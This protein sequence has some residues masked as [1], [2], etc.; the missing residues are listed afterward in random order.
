MEG[1]INCRS[2]SAD[3]GCSKFD[4]ARLARLVLPARVRTAAD[5]SSHRYQVCRREDLATHG[6]DVAREPGR[7]RIDIAPLVTASTSEGRRYQIPARPVR[8]PQPSFDLVRHRI[9]VALCFGIRQRA[10]GRSDLLVDFEQFGTHRLGAV[11]DR[12]HGRFCAIEP[13][14]GSTGHRQPFGCGTFFCKFQLATLNRWSV[15]FCQPV[16]LPLP[17]RSPRGP[18]SGRARA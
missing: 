14:I 5:R 8:S 13:R 11:L 10:F 6:V 16:T 15:S 17:A 12:A 3:G 4:S 2:I 1:Q 18:P 7:F 9:A